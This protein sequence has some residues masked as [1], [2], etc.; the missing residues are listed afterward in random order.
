MIGKLNCWLFDDI[1]S[2]KIDVVVYE[3]LANMSQLFQDIM[4]H[5][6]DQCCHLTTQFE[7]Q[8]G[9]MNYVLDEVQTFPMGRGN[10]YVGNWAAH[11]NV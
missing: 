5:C 9:P 3:S 7:Y 10:F 2:F 1:F 6:T 11:C 4:A 8:V